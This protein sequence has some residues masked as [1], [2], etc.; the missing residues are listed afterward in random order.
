MNIVTVKYLFLAI[1]VKYIYL[2][3]ELL[4][5]ESFYLI[6]NYLVI[7]KNVDEYTKNNCVSFKITSLV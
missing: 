7:N 4:T 3:K 5:L 1:S 2:E 6:N